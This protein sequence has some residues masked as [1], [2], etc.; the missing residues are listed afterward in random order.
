MHPALATALRSIA[1]R[2]GCDRSALPPL[3]EA[4][5][6]EA[7]T[8]VLESNADVSVRFAYGDYRV[9]LGPGPDEVTV[10]DRA[11]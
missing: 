11:Q 5:D 8:A 1:A 7:L 6:P 9:I 2:E 10:I 4:V 3:Y